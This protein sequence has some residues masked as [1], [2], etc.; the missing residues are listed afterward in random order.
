MSP[1]LSTI[2]VRVVDRHD[3]PDVTRGVGAP[4]GSL[5]RA[6]EPPVRDPAPAAEPVVQGVDLAARDRLLVARRLVRVGVPDP[7]ARP[8]RP[9]QRHDL[10][11]A[12]GAGRRG[13]EPGSCR[14]T[15]PTLRAYRKRSIP[16][17]CA[18]ASA[19]AWKDVTRTAASKATL[20]AAARRL[21]CGNAAPPFLRCVERTGGGSSRRERT[22][23]PTLV[24]RRDRLGRVRG[25]RAR[26]VEG[27]EG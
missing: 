6:G 7:L 8:R 12:I 17:A 21:R 13:C 22:A 10:V 26:R 24:D 27:A 5:R 20:A 19:G 9:V 3:V 14:P 15:R 1:R 25:T 16:F 18:S 23:K 11:P 2:R 4:A